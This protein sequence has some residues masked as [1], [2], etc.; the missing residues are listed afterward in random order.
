LTLPWPKNQQRPVRI[1]VDFDNTIACYDGVFYEAALEKGLVEPGI[2]ATKASVRD[3]LRRQGKEPDWTALQGYV[4]GARMPDV[5]PFPGVLEFF[6]SCRQ[7]GVPVCIISHKTRYPFVG[8]RYDLHEA[9][10]RWLESNGFYRSAAISRGE[11]YFELTL[12]EKLARIGSMQCSHFIDDL[13]ELLLEPNF[14]KSVERMLFAPQTKPAADFP[15][16]HVSSW[17]EVRERL[18]SR[19]PVCQ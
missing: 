11:V 12:Q 14:P 4:Y 17:A 10:D 15:F 3:S 19:E 6:E 18:I 13:P 9:S 2:P 5:E 7:F 16:Q 1:G 8:P